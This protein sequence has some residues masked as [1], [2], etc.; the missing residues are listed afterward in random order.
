MGLFSSTTTV[1]VAST[2]YNMAGSI[3]DR[4]NYLKSS[5]A[6]AV[7][8]GTHK[9]SLADEITYSNMHGPTFDQR[10]FYRWAVANYPEGRIEGSATSKRSLTADDIDLVS[11]GATVP[12]G[13]TL[14]IRSA[15]IDTADI[16]YWAERYLL[17]NDAEGYAENWI[18]DYIE[19]TNE[20]LINFE[21]G[22]F[23]RVVVGDFQSNYEY[24]VVYYTSYD[25][26]DEDYTGNDRVYLYLIG[27]G[28]TAIDDLSVPT[29]TYS[30]FYPVIPLRIHNKSITHSDFN[31]TYPQWEKAYSKSIDDDFKGMLDKIEDNDDIGDIDHATL[32]FGVEINAE[33]KHSK[34]YIYEFLKELKSTQSTSAIDVTDWL[35]ESAVYKE[36]ADNL[37]EWAASQE[38]ESSFWY[39]KP[40]P[41]TP[42][43]KP[44]TVNSISIKTPNTSSSPIENHFKISWINIS[45]TLS[46]GVGKTGAKKGDMWW[47]VLPSIDNG[48]LI[49]NSVL[50]GYFSETS[51]KVS[52]VKLYWQYANNNYKT[53]EIYGLNHQNLIYAG[54]AVTIH[55]DEGIDDTDASGFFFPLHYPTLKRI[56]LVDANEL[57]INNR[58]LIFNS[59]KS[60]TKKWYQK[61]IWAIIA[62]IVLAVVFPPAVGVL[63]SSMMVGVSLGFAMGT[64]AALI[65]GAVA[66]AIAGIILAQVIA[67]ASIALL[68]E[69]VGRIVAAVITFAIASGSISFDST[70]GITANLGNMMRMDNLMQITNVI[71][72]GIQGV[73]SGKIDEISGEM[74]TADSAYEKQMEEI[75]KLMYE[76]VGDGNTVLD[77]LDLFVDL[78]DSAGNGSAGSEIVMESSDRFIK[79][80]TL[81]G[82]DFIEIQ[83]ALI[84]KFAEISL[85]LPETVR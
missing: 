74:E 38:D 28:N 30:D 49:S 9:T 80:T 3:L 71:S 23:I 6:R 69:D 57:A 65:A 77:P 52:H 62:I 40:R 25:D 82:S 85:T 13:H 2:V 70:S 46:S 83:L 32:V 11:A 42:V 26:V 73:V 34:R 41:V 12:T 64:S 59:Y 14:E 35:D 1:Y 7:L 15:F 10:M 44:G 4:P 31:S 22:T 63:G 60:V 58:L 84:D 16:S 43:L 81:T 36:A 50:S 68:G 48:S 19:S 45:E 18:S 21:D 5:V 51:G 33:Q 66:N 39:G 20:V 17:E 56:P 8:T 24:L 55:A 37:V 75:N 67:G 53:L 27:S 78:T 61:G 29:Q 72:E 54:K 79:R 47:E 76:M